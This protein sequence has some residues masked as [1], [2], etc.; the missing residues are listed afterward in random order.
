MQPLCCGQVN[1]WGRS[2]GSCAGG[3]AEAC[4]ATGLKRKG[5]LPARKNLQA[6]GQS[7]LG[8]RREGGTLIGSREDSGERKTSRYFFGAGPR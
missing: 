4:R 1:S 6:D 5:R 3:H 8:S 7:P 2:L